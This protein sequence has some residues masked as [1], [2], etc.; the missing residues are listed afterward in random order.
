MRTLTVASSLPTLI[1]L[2]FLFACS[3]YET[4]L[5]PEGGKALAEA[6]KVNTTLQSIE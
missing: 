1:S 5:G 2:S 3:L 6:L 4:K